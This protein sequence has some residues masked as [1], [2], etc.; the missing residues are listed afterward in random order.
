[1]QMKSWRILRLAGVVMLA[2]AAIF[3]ICALSDPTLGSTLY[4][5]NFAIGAEVWRVFY[6]IYLLSAVVMLLAS[7]VLK[8]AGRK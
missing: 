6:I 2:A 8:R 5:G 3:V 7:F 1:M 4:I